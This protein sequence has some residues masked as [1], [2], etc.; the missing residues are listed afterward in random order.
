MVQTG[1]GSST[2]VLGPRINFNVAF[3]TVDTD[4]TTGNVCAKVNPVVQAHLKHL[5]D[6][7]FWTRDTALGELVAL[8]SND[9]LVVDLPRGRSKVRALEHVGTPESIQITPPS[10]ES[11]LTV[12]RF[13]ATSRGLEDALKSI[14]EKS[15]DRTDYLFPTRTDT[16]P[17]EP[18]NL[19]RVSWV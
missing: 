8:V 2:T 12:Q 1:C 10:L 11:Q 16:R 18:L 5:S 13:R 9:L 3:Y 15:C 7:P 19:P 14:Y 6:D 17:S 4:T